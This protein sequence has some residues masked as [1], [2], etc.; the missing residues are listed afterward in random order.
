MHEET[1]EPGVPLATC[2][3]QT[4]SHATSAEHVAAGELRA[5]AGGEIDAGARLRALRG[6][7]P[8]AGRA[9]GPCPGARATRPHFHSAGTRRCATRLSPPSPHSERRP[10]RSSGLGSLSSRARRPRDLAPQRDACPAAGC[11]AATRAQAVACPLALRR[12]RATDRTTQTRRSASRRPVRAPRRPLGPRPRALSC[13]QHPA[14]AGGR[15]WQRPPKARG[16]PL[17]PAAGRAR[18]RAASGP[19]APAARSHPGWGPQCSAAECSRSP[20]P[21]AHRSSA[22]RRRSSAAARSAP[23]GMRSAVRVAARRGRRGA[24]G[25]VALHTCWPWTASFRSEPAGCAT[26]SASMSPR[27][28]HTAVPPPSAAGAPAL[29][30]AAQILTA[31]A[32][33][34]MLRAHLPG[35][36]G[37]RAPGRSGEHL[38]AARAH[39]RAQTRTPMA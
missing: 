11:C 17:A 20:R 3:A 7:L 13:P 33:P 38:C 9:T 39:A 32:G 8:C 15:G 37:E 22:R 18:W 21:P 24:R 1:R 26:L 30:V 10:Q 27:P 14:R 6:T 35:R 5:P 23:A 28:L 12:R 36:G 25:R 29:S 34:S 31:P 4:L 19:R 16:S 2:R